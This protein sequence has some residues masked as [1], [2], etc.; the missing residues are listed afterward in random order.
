[1]K[2]TYKII[3]AITIPIIISSSI[4]GVLVNHYNSK[5]N[6]SMLDQAILGFME[7]YG[8]PGVAVSAITDNEIIWMNS[9]GYGNIE[10]NVL[11]TGDTLFMLGSISKS[12]VSTAFMQ[13]VEQNLVNLDDNINNYLP[14]NI[15]HPNYPTSTITPRMLLTHTSGITDNWYIIYPMQTSGSDSPIDIDEFIFNYLHENGSYFS[16]GNFNSNEPGTGFDYTNVGS[17]LVAYLIEE[18][19][20]STFEHY[21]QENLFQPLDM[22]NTSWRLSNLNEDNI[23]IPYRESYGHF[24]PMEHYGSPVYPC[25]FLRTSV[26]QFSHFLMTIINDGKYGEIELIQNTSVM[27]MTTVQFPSLSSTG[28]FWQNDGEYWGHGGSGPGVSTLMLFHPIRKQ[29]VIV[30]TNVE[31]PEV[32]SLILNEVFMAWQYNE[33]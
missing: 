3:L 12:V 10:E 16:Y 31:K 2:K 1:M 25:G 13:L 9:Y 19:S 11:V 22:P 23:A 26:R 15:S 14:F 28:L 4:V 21:C 33:I 17:T 20:N 8:V 32:T 5:N 29:G 24:F 18:I 6:L 7:E 27:P 30:F